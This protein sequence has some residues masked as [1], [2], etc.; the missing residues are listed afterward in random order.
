LKIAVVS[1]TLIHKGLMVSCLAD[2]AGC[3]ER[4]TLKN[5]PEW[6][7]YEQQVA[8]LITALDSNAEVMHN[9]RVRGRLSSVMRQVDVWVHGEIIGQE[10]TIAIEC[11]MTSR[12]VEIGEVDK[13][14][15]KLLDL[16]AE[17]GVLYSASGMTV[18]AVYRTEGAVSPSVVPVSLAAAP[19]P[20]PY[21]AP[22]PPDGLDEP[23]YPEWLSPRI[24]RHILTG[25]RWVQSW[26][27]YDGA[28]E[29]DS[30]W[31][32]LIDAVDF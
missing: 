21:G 11:K 16:G 20:N 12:P 27:R 18:N 30:K 1:T 24:Y 19:G 25:K 2:R 6:K 32:G 13:F 26:V 8:Q 28:W 31:Q 7:K 22:G 3:S 5:S 9:K 17:R 4:M 23:D 29:P 10:I 15:G 14:V